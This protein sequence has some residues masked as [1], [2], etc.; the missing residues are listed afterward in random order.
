MSNRDD[1][2]ADTSAMGNVYKDPDHDDM[3]ALHAAI[4]ADDTAHLYEMIIG[5][6]LYDDD[7]EAV[8]AACIA[9]STHA[10][11]NIRGNAILGFG[12]LA[13]RFRSL[14]SES[15]AIVRRGLKDPSEY[16]RGHAYAAA[17]DLEMFLH[18]RLAKMVRRVLG[19]THRRP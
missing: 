19:M 7:R 6:A 11:E 10:D 9:L 3:D 18:G 15:R 17:G 16:V 4:A 5:A 2:P 14:K 12:H 13:R 1:A 8:E